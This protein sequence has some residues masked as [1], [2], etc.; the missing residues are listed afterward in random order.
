MTVAALTQARLARR[1]I[2]VLGGMGPLATADFMREIILR[3]PATGDS[4]HIPLLV[5]SLPQL[6]D[7]VGPI[8]TGAGESPL[9]ALRERLKLLLDG[10]AKCIA[11][12]CN[13]AH[14]WYDELARDCPARFL[15]IVD[16]TMVELRG[17]LQ[18]PAA[19]GVLGTAATL[20]AELFQRPLRAAGYTPLTPA[21]EVLASLVLP[22]IALV[23]KNRIDDAAALFRSALDSMA[24]AALVILAC[25]EVPAALRGDPERLARSCLDPNAALAQ[26]CVDWAFSDAD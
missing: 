7:R 21:P 17:R 23:K 2:G 20:K 19:I 3:T 25:T 22:G 18:P 13:T 8:M 10:G 14:Y 9:P 1:V 16:V 12:P 11:M 15:N 26:A 6:P 24:G 5:A 4:G